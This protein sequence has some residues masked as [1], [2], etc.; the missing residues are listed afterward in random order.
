[1]NGTSQ[2]VSGIT[3]ISVD[4]YN[5]KAAQCIAL[6]AELQAMAAERDT[7]LI[8]VYSGFAIKVHEEDCTVCGHNEAPCADKKRLESEN[9]RAFDAVMKMGAK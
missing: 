6:R 4:E 5:A 1:M 3:F 2:T 8:Y 7:L 9:M